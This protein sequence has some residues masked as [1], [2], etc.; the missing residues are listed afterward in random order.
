VFLAVQRQVILVLGHQHLRQQPGGGDALVDDVRWHGGLHQGL[1]LRAN[2]LA[3]DVALDREDAGRVV[4]LLGHVFADALELA[5][6]TA[7]GVLGLVA[8]LGARQ[9]ARQHGTLGLL[10]VACVLAR[11][12]LFDLQGQRRQVGVDGLFDEALLLGVEGLGLGRELQPLEHRHLVG[13]LVDGGLLEGDL[14]ALA[15]HLGE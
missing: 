7:G 5:A 9:I 2:P 13:E 8:M 12:A 11:R 6:T 14:G 15:G 1:A 3:A 4:Q 10:L